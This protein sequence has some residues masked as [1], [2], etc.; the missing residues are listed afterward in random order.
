MRNVRIEIVIIIVLKLNL[1]V[2]LGQGSSYRLGGLARIDQSQ[3][4]HKNSYYNS[5]KT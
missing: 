3:R 4:K 5:F 1:K 2:D